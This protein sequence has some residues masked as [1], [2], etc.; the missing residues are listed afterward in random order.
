M[1]R[2]KYFHDH[3]AR[4][5]HPQLIVEG[6]EHTPTNSPLRRYL[7]ESA[8]CICLAKESDPDTLAALTEAIGPQNQEI[9]PAIMDV[10]KNKM[11]RNGIE[12]DDPD[13][14]DNMAFHDLV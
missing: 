10:I 6:F 8:A 9:W 5:V 13:L 3:I 12:M 1:D 4:W 11:L 14:K 2:I 7:T